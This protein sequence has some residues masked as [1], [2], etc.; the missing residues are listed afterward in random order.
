MS[1]NNDTPN[2]IVIDVPFNDLVNNIE[3]IEKYI[4]EKL[5]EKTSR[6][7][8]SFGIKQIS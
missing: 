6:D 3:D 4:K 7:V 1:F 8:I 2:E 5:K